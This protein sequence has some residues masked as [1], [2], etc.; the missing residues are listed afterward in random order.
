MPTGSLFKKTG[1]KK[2][3]NWRSQPLPPQILQP[4][5]AVLCRATPTSPQ[6]QVWHHPGSTLESHWRSQVCVPR[7]CWQFSAGNVD[8]GH[9][10]RTGCRQP[11]A[12]SS[13]PQ[14]NVGLLS[15]CWGRAKLGKSHP[16]SIPVTPLLHV[17]HHYGPPSWALFCM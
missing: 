8:L 13:P 9:T 11:V 16:V 15:S 17:I 5:S 2:K 6:A 1:G 14:G 10:D 12:R 4:C 7:Q 3:K